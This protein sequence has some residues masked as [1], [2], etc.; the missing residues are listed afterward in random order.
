[1]KR[2]SQLVEELRDPFEREKNL[3]PK[4]VNGFV[5]ASDGKSLIKIPASMVDREFPEAESHPVIKFLPGFS[6]DE[7][8]TFEI[9][10]HELRKA[11]VNSQP[12]MIDC[13]LCF[14]S[15]SFKNDKGEFDP[16]TYVKINEDTFNP[17]FLNVLDNI[18]YLTNVPKIKCYNDG[19]HR[20]AIFIIGEVTFATAPLI[21]CKASEGKYVTLITINRDGVLLT[22]R[23]L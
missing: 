11:I 2:F 12:E 15:E 4:T 18:A 21:D 13:P 5:C 22:G 14:S 6:L 23:N 17:N 20:V 19:S 10:V 1:M 9:D 3:D 8:S 16:L 7:E